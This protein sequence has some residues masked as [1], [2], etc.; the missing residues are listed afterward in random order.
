MHKQ[1]RL[2]LVVD[3]IYALAFGML[4]PIYAVF[5]QQIG[6]DILE[7]GTAWAIFMISSGIGIFLMG[8]LQDRISKDKL[9]LVAGY[10]MRSLGFL[11]YYFVSN[12]TQMF[13]LQI[14]LGLSVVII[15]PATYSFYSKHVNS[16]K[17]AFEWSLW[18]GMWYIAQGSGALAGGF[19][20]S[21]YGFKTLFLA[22]FG[23]S[24]VSLI[25]ATQLRE[26]ELKNGM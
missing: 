12:V 14:L 6:G 15:S 17:R 24:I 5:V 4:G 25:I 2:F 3:G 18:E 26:S 22:M 21:L 19:L 10:A 7:A 9:F 13:V 1:L 20:A 8:K 11:G 23:Y 16:K